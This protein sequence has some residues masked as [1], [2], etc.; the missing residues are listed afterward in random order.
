MYQGSKMRD[1]ILLLKQLNKVYEVLAKYA[2]SRKSKYYY[3]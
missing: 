1:S 3:Q 2:S